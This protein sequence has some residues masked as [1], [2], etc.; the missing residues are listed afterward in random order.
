MTQHTYKIGSNR[1]GPF[2]IFTSRSKAEE[3]AIE[4]AKAEPGLTV[5]LF[6]D[7]VAVKAFCRNENGKKTWCDW[8]NI[9]GKARS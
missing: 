6:V 8:S 4:R 1:N 2:R 7:D 3:I 9:S 5:G